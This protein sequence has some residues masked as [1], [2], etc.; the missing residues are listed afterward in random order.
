MSNSQILSLKITGKKYLI[1]SLI[2]CA[3]VILIPNL[4]SQ[5]TSN[6]ASSFGSIFVSAVV[7][8][9]SVVLLFKCDSKKLETV[10]VNLITNAIEVIESK[11]Q[12]DIRLID[13]NDYVLIE[14]EDSGPGI[15]ENILPKIFEPLFT[16]KQT[17]I[18]LGLPSCKNMTEQHGG[19]ITVK[20]NPTVFT[21]KL[22]KDPSQTK[23][24]I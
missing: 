7:T 14:I 17:G 18:G 23:F 1:A 22:P 16:T 4:V 10:F 13:K 19:I 8:L 2:G 24:L 6:L 3:L 21:I 20:T 12:I 15:P 9:L 5:D 11:G